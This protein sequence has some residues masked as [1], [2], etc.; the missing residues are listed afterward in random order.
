MDYTLREV[1]GKY[2]VPK[3]AIRVARLLGFDE[4]ILKLAEKYLN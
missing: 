1:Y 4:E 2:E 3:D